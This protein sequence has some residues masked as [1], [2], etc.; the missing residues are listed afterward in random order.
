[1]KWGIMFNIPATYESDLLSLLPPPTNKRWLTSSHGKNTIEALYYFQYTPQSWQEWQRVA[2][3]KKQMLNRINVIS[4]L[5][6]EPPEIINGSV[7]TVS[8]LGKYFGDFIKFPKPMFPS[9]QDDAYQKL[10]WHAM[11]LHHQ[12]LLFIEQLIAISIKFSMDSGVG[13]TQSLK[14]AKSVYAFAQEN[15][16]N[17]KQRLGK[18]DLSKVLLESNKKSV[19]IRQK[20]RD[21]KRQ[22]AIGLKSDGKS[23]KEITEILGVNRR[24]ITRWK[25]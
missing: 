23:I 9:S 18:E 6:Y 19:A 11:R 5:D 10:C 20:N 21:S 14:R 8:E 17:W 24:T 3:I 22:I 25:I 2:S 1:M 7:Y 13:L 12:S 15:K 16:A 4:F